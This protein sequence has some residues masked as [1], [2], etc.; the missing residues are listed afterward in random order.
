MKKNSNLLILIGIFGI[1][2]VIFIY[3]PVFAQE[4]KLTNE[5]YPQ[6]ITLKIDELI[7]EKFYIHVQQS[8][9]LNQRRLGII[10]N[11][12]FSE[13]SVYLDTSLI[14][15]KSN[16][17][18]STYYMGWAGAINSI[19][20][21]SKFAI[22]IRFHPM[23]TE[24]NE[25]H[26]AIQLSDLKNPYGYSGY[27]K[28]SIADKNKISDVDVIIYDVDNLSDVEFATIVRHEL[29]HALGL[30]HSVDME[31]LMYPIIKTNYAYIS[32]CNIDALV[33]LYGVN[34]KIQAFR[35]F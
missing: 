2:T 33:N 4:Q 26:I 25:V 13:E 5:K 21:D 20:K 8:H 34:T 9:E 28:P 1:I 23:M 27:T 22:P 35:L 16:C 10:N 24:T 29:G 12:F 19:S 6:Y 14:P 3:N 18:K 31:D 30:T 17:S 11:V 32:Q 15:N 7:N